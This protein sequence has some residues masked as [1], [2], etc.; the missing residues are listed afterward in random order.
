MD[1]DKVD[2]GLKK[3][4]EIL[5]ESKIRQ[6]LHEDPTVKDLEWMI[7]KVEE[8]LP[9]SFGKVREQGLELQKGCRQQL[10]LKRLLDDNRQQRR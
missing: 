10:E 9:Y 8:M 5:L 6:T 4:Q 7:L 1:Q 3:I 2:K